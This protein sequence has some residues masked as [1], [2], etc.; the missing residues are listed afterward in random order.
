[1]PRAKQYL[2]P[3]EKHD[4]LVLFKNYPSQRL[5]KM[6]EKGDI[7]K[8]RHL[9]YKDYLE[10]EMLASMYRAV[11]LY[12]KN[13]ERSKAKRPLFFKRLA[14]NVTEKDMKEVTLKIN[15]AIARVEGTA[16]RKPLKADKEFYA[17]LQRIKNGHDILEDI[18]VE[19][20]K[21]DEFNK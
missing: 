7:I 13:N 21:E 16:S 2:N 9:E 3:E 6:I 8:D 12:D 14:D 5:E 18:F 1:M 17:L 4:L 11:E 19:L 15:A 20:E 10:R